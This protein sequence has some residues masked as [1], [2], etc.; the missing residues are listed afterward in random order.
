[1]LPFVT[2][3]ICGEMVDFSSNWH[4]VHTA[5]PPHS[6]VVAARLTKM[7]R[8]EM[9]LKARNGKLA[10]KIV[11]H[12][13]S[14]TFH[15]MC[16]FCSS[17]KTAGWKKKK[18]RKKNLAAAFHSWTWKALSG[19]LWDTLGAQVGLTFP[20]QFK[21]FCQTGVVGQS[22]MFSRQTSKNQ[23]VVADFE[24]GFRKQTRVW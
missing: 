21:R 10:G 2:H 14:F 22:T 5:P 4:T 3:F 9:G 13:S 1:M 17:T 16:D 20:Q 11:C 6:L 18:I 12:L 23:R 7:L 8:R 15:E 19:A 24:I